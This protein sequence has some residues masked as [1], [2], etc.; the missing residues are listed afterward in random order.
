MPT[1]LAQSKPEANGAGSKVRA[2]AITARGARGSALRC[3]RVLL[4]DP[5]LSNAALGVRRAMSPGLLGLQLRSEGFTAAEAEFDVDAS[6]SVDTQVTLDV[7]RTAAPAPHIETAEVSAQATAVPEPPP[8]TTGGARAVA[9]WIAFGVG[10]AGLALGGV[11]GLVA[12]GQH[13]HLTT[14]C[15]GI[16]CPR[17]EQND[18]DQY[19]ATAVASTIGFIAGGAGVAT[20]AILLLTQPG[21]EGSSLARHRQARLHVAPVIGFGSIGAAGE[22]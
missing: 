9:P 1:A 16:Q 3:P 19:H 4:D 21:A 11:A 7:D 18:I 22:F 13:S 15:G 14:V 17:T 2:A 6:G 20:G 12:M 5:P 10:A 8:S